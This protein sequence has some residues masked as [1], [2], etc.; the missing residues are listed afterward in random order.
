MERTLIAWNVPN[1][2]TIPLMAAVGFL[3][4]AVVWQLVL[5]VQG[6]QSDAPASTAAGY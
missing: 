2:I 4:V 3:A 1:M 6:S 5:K